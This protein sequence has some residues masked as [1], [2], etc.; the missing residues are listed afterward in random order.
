MKKIKSLLFCIVLFFTPSLFATTYLVQLGTGGAA[1]WSGVTGTV[2]NL[3]TVNAGASASFN[4]WYADKSLTTPLFSGAKFTTADKVWVAKGTYT[5]TGTVNLYPGV[6]IYGGF[7]GTETATTLRA[8][9]S[10]DLWDFSNATVF[11]GANSY[12]GISAGS[13]TTTLVDGLTI[14][15]CHNSA[16]SA[17]GG[18]AYLYGSGN[19]LQ[20]CII[21][22]CTTNSTTGSGVSAGIS[23]SNAA[24]V[25]DS[26]IHH[27]TS[28]AT[29]QGGGGICLRGNLCTV[30]GCKIEY[31]AAVTGGGLFFYTTASGASIS[32]CSFSNNSSTASGGGIGAYLNGTSHTSPITISNCTFTSNTAGANGGGMELRFANSYSNNNIIISDCI[33][34]SNTA[35]AP[36]GNSAFGGGAIRAFTCALDVHN[37][38]F[39]SNSTTLANGGAILLYSTT[40]ATINNSK[41]IA[42][43]AGTTTSYYGAA[44]ACSTSAP[45][46]ANNC[47]IA[48]NIGVNVI[49][50]YNDAT[51][52]TFQ[53]CT[54]ASNVTSIGGEAPIKLLALTPQ[55]SFA[56]CL[57][58]HSSTFVVQTPTLSYCGFDI[59]I[60]SGGT[61][62]ITGITSATFNN[63][64]GG[65]Y[66]LSYG[67]NAIDAG[68]TIATCTP[69]ITGVSRPQCGAYDLGA[70]ETRAVSTLATT[71][72]TSIA[73]TTATSGGNVTVGSCSAISARGV[74]WSTVT[75]PTLSDS[76]TSDGGTT[77]SYSSSLTGLLPGSDYFVRA[78]A[79]SAQGTVYGSEINFT[80]TGFSVPILSSTTAIT[81]NITPTASSG[82]NVTSAQGAAITVRGVCWSTSHNPTTADSKTTDAGTTGSFTSALTGLSPN[83]TYY[84]RSYATN[85]AGTGYGAEVS[86]TTLKSEPTNQPTSFVKGTLA[87]TT[88]TPTFT[89]AVAGAQAPDGY[90]LKMSSSA[91]VAPVDGVDPVD[92][93]ALSGGLANVKV[94]ASP[95]SS[96]TGLTA[97]T[98]YNLALYSYTNS[99]ASINFNTTGAPTMTVATSPDSNIPA[100][101]ANSTT[102]AIIS[103]PAVTN[104]NHSFVVFMKHSAAITT[105]T[106]TNAPFTYTANAAFT[107]GT[108][109]QNDAAAYCVYKGSGT[110]VTV[111][112]LTFGDTY[113]ILAYVIVNTSNSDG[114]NSYSN[115]ETASVVISS[116]PEPTNQ[117]TSF[118]HGA[119]TT[120][121]I[122][123]TW[124]SA[125]A[126]GQSPDGYL[127]KLNTGAIADPMDGTDPADVTTVTGNAAN[128]KITPNTASNTNS[129]DGL[130]AGTMYNYNIYSYTNSGAYINYKITSIPSFHVATLPNPVT[131]GTLTYNSG[132]TATIAWSAASGYSAGNHSTLV[133]VKATTAITQGTPSN[134]PSTY[135]AVTNFAGAG[136]S[137]QNDA[138]AKCVYNGDGTNVS[139]SGLDANTSYTV[140]IYTVV[141]ASNSDGTNAY[142]SALVPL[143]VQSITFN[144]LEGKTYG[145]APFTVSATGGRSGNAVV[146]TSSD[147]AV[148]TCSGSNGSTVTIVG[149]GNCTIY[150]DQAGNGSHSAATQVGQSLTVSKANQTITFDALSNKTDS[151]LPYTLS[152]TLSSGLSVTYTSSNTAVA[153]VLGSTINIIAAGT[154]DIT[155]SRAAD[156][157]FN[158]AAD[159]IR[160]LTVTTTP[161]ITI[162]NSGN[163]L[164]SSLL[165]SS[166][167]DIT[168]PSGGTL[169]VDGYFALHDIVVAPGGKLDLSAAVVAFGNVTFKEDSTGS[170]STNLGS[171]G[172]SVSGVV[173]YFKTIDNTQWHFISFPCDV[174]LT[175]IKKSDG[176][177]LGTLNTHW[178]LKYYD[179][180]A[181]T[182]NLG[183]STNWKNVTSHPTAPTKL[184]AY[185]GYILG[186]ANTQPLTEIQFPLTSA[187]ITSEPA[188]D[189]GV[190]AYGSALPIADNHKGWNLVGQPYLSNYDLKGINATYMTRWNGTAYTEWSH[191]DTANMKPFE[192][193]FV[194][195]DAALA[196]SDLTFALESRQ[197]VRSS[198]FNDLTDRIQLNISTAFGTDRT[199]VIL[200]DSES[201][202]YQI[203]HDL[204]KWLT[205][206]EK[207]Q[208]FTNLSGV[209]YA[210]NAL[211]VKD[212]QNLPLGVYSKATGSSTISADLSNAPGISQ[213]LLTDHVE[214]I[215][216]DLMRSDYNFTASAGTTNSRFTLAAQR[217]T[218]LTDNHDAPS[219]LPIISIMNG[220]LLVKNITEKTKI[221][222]F[223]SLGRMIAYKE[224]GDSSL[225]IPLVGSG[226][227]TVMLIAGEKS[228]VRKV[229]LG[230]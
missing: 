219:N 128:I 27:N 148:A 56:N 78:Y 217:V 14:Q 213:L 151:D 67:S 61:N 116:K 175:D 144:A 13:S 49:D 158:A 204:E 100:I 21:T 94:T 197:L 173:R 112:G 75:A 33:F 10:A 159:V 12:V 24:S 15:N 163:T 131:S 19:T 93:T 79:T 200:D 36:S 55:Y 136:T 66:T 140:L 196:A 171:S 62:C 60:P 124:T 70:Y 113:H 226:V 208:I 176:N 215:T 209:N 137:Y 198:V 57:F 35:A 183:A 165:S 181:R 143:A 121:S 45:L 58:Y 47:L 169:T 99:G 52:S 3:S 194:Q 17:S 139:I 86:F 63:A 88:L 8:I 74:C 170:F 39:N 180:D 132:T 188:H 83:T 44:I 223:D 117:P 193:F 50:F 68:T 28:T 41:F 25:K 152:G 216:T 103:F 102:S 227:Y 31:N 98:F 92:A 40:S 127:I 174:L 73:N 186:L 38:V 187:V 221:R 77:G 118:T 1:A 130:V 122:P 218:T 37:S 129:F 96:I 105:G 108:A 225:E 91:I 120:T 184:A 2:V 97:G 84:V 6:S 11:D 82:G 224:T 230:N 210:Y 160:S 81:N 135:T 43:T 222:V 229:I 133:F 20:K 115:G 109:F 42:N 182:A 89:A 16:T 30:S 178:F 157:N 126:G 71:A 191:F 69:D 195:A 29:V 172:I 214:N 9:S 211:P 85:A 114:T 34:S 153:V 53:N 123:L 18:G 150:A 167:C 107:S 162:P 4:A 168:I 147:P 5:L 46:T 179:G 134:A 205:K 190:V 185:Q 154:T 110:S 23:I 72:A 155:A 192:A 65:D 212:A 101:S 54:F 228:C 138:S 199:T 177:S 32:N 51:A 87:S 90:L 7:A 26:Y 161:P 202:A 48:S 119:V 141:D 189:V 22:A 146:F 104:V 76:Y 95:A 80:T 207:P 125:V 111:T 106:P 220:N 59:A 142:S 166:T 156:G 201:T 145:D 203:N 206:A 64:A 149:A 164:S